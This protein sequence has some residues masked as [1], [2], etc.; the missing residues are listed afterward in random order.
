MPVCPPPLPDFWPIG[1]SSL[2]DDYPSAEGWRYAFEAD[3]D[4]DLY[5]TKFVF[6]KQRRTVL[7]THQGTEVGIDADGNLFVCVRGDLKVSAHGEMQLLAAED[8][9]VQSGRDVNILA[10]RDVNICADGGDLSLKASGDVVMRADTGEFS[11]AAAGQ[12]T[13]TSDGDNIV[14]TPGP[15]MEVIDPEPP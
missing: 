1:D 15:G 6:N 9:H 12:V 10:A 8:V 2:Y 14:L 4:G 7:V 3:A 13:I 5:E 11:A